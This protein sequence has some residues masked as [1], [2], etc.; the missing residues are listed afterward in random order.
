MEKKYRKVRFAEQQWRLSVKGTTL[1]RHG[2]KFMIC[3]AFL[4]FSSNAR[5]PESRGGEKG[6]QKGTLAMT[7]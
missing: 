7:K 4:A 1:R 3:L 5:C 6:A 2:S